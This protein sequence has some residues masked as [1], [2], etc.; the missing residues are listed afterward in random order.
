MI[1]VFCTIRQGQSKFAP[2]VAAPFGS[3]EDLLLTTFVVR[4]LP[5][6]RVVT[7]WVGRFWLVRVW[8]WERIAGDVGIRMRRGLRIRRHRQVDETI[9][10]CFR[11]R[12]NLRLGSRFWLGK[13]HAPE[14]PRWT[15]A[16]PNRTGSAQRI[17]GSICVATPLAF[18]VGL[19]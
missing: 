5:K 12:W 15:C 9:D 1:D 18:D 11:I 14:I 6:T 7:R 8:I 2:A 19:R 3:K 16:I 17:V 13:C 4:P 10:R